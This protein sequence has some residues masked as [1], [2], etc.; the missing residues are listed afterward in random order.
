MPDLT[1]VTPGDYFVVIEAHNDDLSVF[2]NFYELHLIVTDPCLNAHIYL[3]PDAN[4]DPANYYHGGSAV[5]F[6]PEF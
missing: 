3:A 5:S 6:R 2:S 4:A 1:D